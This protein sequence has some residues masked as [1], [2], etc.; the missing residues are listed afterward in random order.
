MGAEAGVNEVGNIVQN[1]ENMID[2]TNW[3]D[4]SSAASAGLKFGMLGMQVEG[5]KSGVQTTS[6]SGKV[7]G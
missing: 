2:N 4:A 1:M 5:V 6:E 7:R 3:S